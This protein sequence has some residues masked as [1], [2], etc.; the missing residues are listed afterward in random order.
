MGINLCSVEGMTW[1][2]L[3]D[4]QMVSLT[5]HFKPV[6]KSDRGEKRMEQEK[7]ELQKAVCALESAGFHVD[8]AYEEDNRDAGNIALNSQEYKTGAICLRITPRKPSP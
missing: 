2:E 5:I 4:G 6:A 7:S 3:A 1:S 8:R